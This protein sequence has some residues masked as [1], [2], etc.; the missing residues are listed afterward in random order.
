MFL[1]LAGIE[2]LDDRGN[3]IK[4]VLAARCRRI[5]IMPT[6]IR[7]VDQARHV[8]PRDVSRC[9]NLNSVWLVGQIRSATGQPPFWSPVFEYLLNPCYGI[10]P[11]LGMQHRRGHSVAF[12]DPNF[13]V[14]A[15]PISEKRTNI[16]GSGYRD[17]DST[18]GS[19]T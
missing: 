7:N 17:D 6:R 2:S 1:P 16:N 19:Q 3:L 11:T 12:E 4:H 15:V 18:H 5:S 10:I 14:C 8:K 9:N 13:D